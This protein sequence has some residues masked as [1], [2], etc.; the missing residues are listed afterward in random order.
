M[1]LVVVVRRRPCKAFCDHCLWTSLLYSSSVASSF[2]LAWS[3]S[4]GVCVYHLLLLVQHE[5]AMGPVCLRNMSEGISPV[6]HAAEL[7]RSS[8]FHPFAV[9][10]LVSLSFAARGW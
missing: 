6:H 9:V 8:L 3:K 4:S 10:E 7:Y 2:S 5:K 1:F